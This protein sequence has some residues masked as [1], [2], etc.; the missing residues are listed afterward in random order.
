MLT[1]WGLKKEMRFCQIVKFELELDV[2]KGKPS[3]KTHLF[4]W[5]MI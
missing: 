3:E 5:H 4:F 2:G 1:F